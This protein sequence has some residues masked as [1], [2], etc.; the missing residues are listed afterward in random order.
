MEETTEEIS[1]GFVGPKSQ[2]GEVVFREKM[3]RKERL[4][5]AR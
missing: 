3:R 1:A 4:D 5:K 2:G